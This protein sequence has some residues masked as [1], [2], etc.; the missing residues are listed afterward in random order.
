MNDV[1]GYALRIGVIISVVVIIAGFILAIP[2]PNFYEYESPHSLFNTSVIKPEQVLKGSIKGNGIDL[3]LLG[4]IILIAT[5]VL[6]VILGILQFALEKN[7]IYVIITCIV[8]FNLLLAIF[9][10]PIFVK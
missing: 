10:I 7:K 9:V 1:I 6:R 5:P 3:I 4:L 8:L 2:N